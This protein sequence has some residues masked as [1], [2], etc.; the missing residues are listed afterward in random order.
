MTNVLL[1]HIG[2]IASDCSQLLADPNSEDKLQVALF[3]GAGTGPSSFALMDVI[4]EASDLAL[5]QVGPSEMRAE[6][7][8]Q[9]DVVVFP[10]GSGSKQG[11]AIGESGQAAVRKF[12]ESGG[13]YVGVCAGAYLCSA[14]YKWS[15][16]LIDSRP[17]A[18][19]VEI[20]GKGKK[21]LWYR[22][23]EAGIDMELTPKGESLFGGKG[24]PKDFEVRYANGPIISPHG[25]ESLDDYEV[26][27]W[28]R[29]ENGLLEKQ[30]GSM[31]NTPAIVSGQFGEGRVVSVSP[32]PE[33]T[34]ELHPIINQ[35]VRWAAGQLE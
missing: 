13:G 24:I 20:P 34:P 19:T 8:D 22:G 28:F 17:F 3:D 30:K 1:N 27:A 31:I 7:L 16:D 6:V 15:L 32:H 26:L 35:V 14:N 21:N 23:A 2:L 25:S 9:F 4:D 29:S 11:K 10:G 33:L 18:G 12:I 5:Q